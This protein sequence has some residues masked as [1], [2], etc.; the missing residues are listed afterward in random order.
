MS[1]PFA[2]DTTYEKVD[3]SVQYNYVTEYENCTFSNSNFSGL[4]LDNIKFVDCKF[5]GC[6]FSMVTFTNTTIS[7]CVF[8][9]CKMMGTNFSVCSRLGVSMAFKD[10]IIDYSTF[11]GLK[12]PGTQFCNCSAKECDFSQCDLSSAVFDDSNLDLAIFNNT[13][14]RKADFTTANNFMIDPSSNSIK[15]AKFATTNIMGLLSHLDII[16]Q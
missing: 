14:I 9:S 12:I 6:D 10:S 1:A 15:G 7:D 3:F 5:N 11:A 13:N 2:L 8:D 16:I 4:S